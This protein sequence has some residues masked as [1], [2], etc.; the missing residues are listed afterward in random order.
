MKFT[1]L[2]LTILSFIFV[3]A[4]QIEAKRK[5][6]R[7]YGQLLPGLKPGITTTS[8][9]PR[10]AP[11]ATKKPKRNK[12]TTTTTSVGLTTNRGPKRNAG[13]KPKPK[14]KPKKDFVNVEQTLIQ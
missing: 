8:K 1:I 4:H 9:P 6:P 5:P 3:L 11:T 14:N 10:G 13:N 7:D 2:F 12:S